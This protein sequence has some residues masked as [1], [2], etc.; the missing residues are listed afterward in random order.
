MAKPREGIAE[1]IVEFNAR[2]DPER[3]ELKYRAIR[4]NAFAFL[5]G[6]CHLFYEQLPASGPLKNA[7]L[8]WVCGDLHLENFGSYKGDNRLVYFDLNDFDE[9]VLAPSTWDIVRFLVSVLVGAETLGL[10]PDQAKSLCRT[11]LSAYVNAIQDGKARW[12]ERESAEGLVRELLDRLR[13]RRRKAFLDSR[14]SRTGRKR[15]IRIDGKR[16]LAVARAERTRITAFM[17]KFAKT[18]PNPAFY[19]VIDIA[20][21]IAGTGS[22]GVSRYVLLVEGKGSPDGNYF[23]DLKQALPSA[24]APRL[25][26]KQPKWKTEAHR[27]VALQR[28]VQ[29]I[30]MAFLTPVEIDDVPY[31]L[32]GLQPSEDRVALNDWHGHIERLESVMVTMGRLC[33]WAHLRGSGRQGSAIVDEHIEFWA[34]RSRATKLLSQALEC[35]RQVKRDWQEY[36]RAYDKGVVSAAPAKG[37]RKR[38]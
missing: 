36:C 2:R 32:R 27:V 25:K 34:K 7:P 18:Q 16:A 10:S 26:W 9:A 8:A 6:T 22:L 33:A 11:Y 4:A 15:S 30:S 24:L 35:S 12:I 19:R 1:R 29:A 17:R 21:R 3:L 13:E 23:L 31:V 5:R 20:R 14:T 28:R 37:G 38:T